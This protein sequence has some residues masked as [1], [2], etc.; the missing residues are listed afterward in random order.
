ME[1]LKPCPF[2]GGPACIETKPWN[3]LA[4]D[5]IIYCEGCDSYFLL[6]DVFAKEED[7]VEAWN[8]RANDV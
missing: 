4:R 2:C 3:I 1:K 6:D 7:L 8:R 5:N